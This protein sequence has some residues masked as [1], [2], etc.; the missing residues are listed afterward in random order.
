ML[1]GCSNNVFKSQAALITANGTLR[2]VKNI[3]Y[4]IAD[5]AWNANSLLVIENYKLCCTATQVGVPL[6]AFA[7]FVGAYFG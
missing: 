2:A 3:I 5:L 6:R 4:E 1:L 7:S